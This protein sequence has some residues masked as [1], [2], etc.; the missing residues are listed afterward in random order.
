V[1]ED[2]AEILIRPLVYGD[3]FELAVGFTELSLR[4][5]QLRFF[6]APDALGSDELEY[7]T[8]IDY[9]N[10]FAFAA[11]LLGGPGPKGIGVGR[12]LRNPSDPTIA[13]VAVTVMDVHQRR[14]VGTLLTRA[15]GGV[16]AERG[17]HTFVSYV[18]WGNDLAVE[19]LA[20][21]GARVLPDE[22][23]IARIEIDIPA[24]TA[25]VADSPRRSRLSALQ[26][27]ER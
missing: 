11:L 19:S 22:P 10:H 13:E 27:A 6:Q 2:G 26:R 3:R 16:A 21:E 15:L 12:Y 17:I 9:Q 8:N 18:Q 24:V 20:R 4:S 14:G 23:G 7:L 5:R 1:L 25:D